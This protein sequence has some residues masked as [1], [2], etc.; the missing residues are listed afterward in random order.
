MAIT[1]SPHNL[2][3]WKAGYGESKRC[4][5]RSLQ[6]RQ[7]C[8]RMGNLNLLRAAASLRSP[9]TNPGS[10]KGS[11]TQT[12]TSCATPLAA[13]RLCFGSEKQQR[14]QLPWASLGVSPRLGKEIC[15]PWFSG[16]AP[17]LSLFYCILYLRRGVQ[18]GG[19]EFFLCTYACSVWAS[20]HYLHAPAFA[21]SNHPGALMVLSHRRIGE[22]G[23][24]SHLHLS[25]HCLLLCPFQFCS[26]KEETWYF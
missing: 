9:A 18:L 26:W 12:R 1:G 20:W 21:F 2:S 25:F 13:V 17:S 24:L 14:A 5:W 22:I 7:R 4:Q 19:G 3:I 16:F 15:R 10:G 11:G 6:S 8:C 23:P